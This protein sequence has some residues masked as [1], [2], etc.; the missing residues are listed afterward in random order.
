MMQVGQL[1]LQTARGVVGKALNEGSVWSLS[2]SHRTPSEMEK[3]GSL[4]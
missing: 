3:D 4:V 1:K 2:L